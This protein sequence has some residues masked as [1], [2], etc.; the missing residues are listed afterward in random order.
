[1]AIL[2]E[3]YNPT[4]DAVST[5]YPPYKG[6]QTFTTTSE[7]NIAS[8]KL[9]LYKS[10]NPGTITIDIYGTNAG[11]PTGSSLASGT[12]E[13]T[14]ITTDS[15]GALYEIILTTNPTL[16]NAT[17]YAIV[18]SMAS[19]DA[20]NYIKILRITAGVYYTGDFIIYDSSW[21]IPV[22]DSDATF[23]VYGV[24]DETLAVGTGSFS[25]TGFSINYLIGQ[26]LT[27]AVTN[28]NLTFNNFITEI[29]K[30]SYKI[31]HNSIWTFK[32]KD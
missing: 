32:N 2:Y 17:K 12:L 7:H 28:F 10:G 25:L 9:K 30:Y 31:K 5:I 29:S 6:G 19:G 24:H 27:T 23:Y 11:L 18:L 4:T 15:G 21:S 20:S 13:T 14:G 22:V 26:V 3:S 1:M 16:S 8:V